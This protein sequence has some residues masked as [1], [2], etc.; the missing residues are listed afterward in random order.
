MKKTIKQQLRS[1][2]VMEIIK[3]LPTKE[4]EFIEEILRDLEVAEA[5]RRDNEA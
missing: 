5:E 2:R 3:N 4:Q 1:A